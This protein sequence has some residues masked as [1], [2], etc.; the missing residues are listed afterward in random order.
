MFTLEQLFS[1]HLPDLYNC[2]EF[3]SVK[4]NQHMRGCV[5]PADDPLNVARDDLLYWQHL[6][7]DVPARKHNLD[8]LWLMGFCAIDAAQGALGKVK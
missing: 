4:L 1:M 3:L 8:A 2:A 6:Y 5:L 7:R